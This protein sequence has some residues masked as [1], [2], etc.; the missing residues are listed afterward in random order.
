MIKTI[1][2][3]VI[4][5]LGT[6]CTNTL[7]KG[8]DEIRIVGSSAVLMFAQ[9]VAENYAAHFEFPSPSVE[10]TG[11]GNGFNLFCS[12]I[13][14]QYPDIN[15][16]ARPIS[17][18]ELAS[19]R[20]KGVDDIVEIIVG[21]DILAVVNI[22]LSP[23]IEISVFELFNAISAKVEKDGRFVD[24]PYQKWSDIRPELPDLPIHV[25]GPSPAS[26]YYDAFMELVMKRGCI[27]FPNISS[28]SEE[29]R[30]KLCHNPRQD[31][32]FIAGLNNDN[33]V[34]QWLRS[35]PGAFAIVPNYL[36]EQYPDYISANPIDGSKPKA[37]AI[38][39]GRY[40]FSRPI[41]LYAKKRHI[42]SISGMQEFLYE[43]TAERSIG[44]EGYLADKGFYSL[45][46]Q[47]RNK[48]RDSALSLTPLK[49]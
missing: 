36:L 9:K 35:D 27:L 8:R 24:N 23:Q 37:P 40:P 4:I 38:S 19:C 31:G 29:E 25:M 2:V 26:S 32:A 10:I 5:A 46:E 7:A 43:F 33:A 12:G 45:N 18:A 1:I 39:S 28:L 30:F 14:Y 16:T 20:K 17:D 44:P 48:A 15:V 21:L 13:G 34:L 22:N 47:G 3:I 49:R 42:E 41:Y 11:G 6:V